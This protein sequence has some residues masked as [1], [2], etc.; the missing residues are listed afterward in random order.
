MLFD[1]LRRRIRKNVEHEGVGPGLRGDAREERVEL[2]LSAGPEVDESESQRA[3]QS[4]GVGHSRTARRGAVRDARPDHHDPVT[5]GVGSGFQPRTFVGSDLEGGD[6][7]VQ[8]EVEQALLHRRIHVFDDGGFV[9]RSG[10]ARHTDSGEDPFAVAADVEVEPALCDER[11]IGSGELVDGGP[12]GADV[13]AV[14]AEH[15]G[16]PR[17][18]AVISRDR[19]GQLGVAGHLDT[20][21]RRTSRLGFVNDREICRVRIFHRRVLRHGHRRDQ[22]TEDHVYPFFHASVFC[23]RFISGSRNDIIDAVIQN[24]ATG[25]KS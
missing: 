10:F 18:V 14:G 11:R 2:A 9:L 13:A 3:A 7:V 12:P 4:C 21:E 1:L 23:F 15:H 16:Q 17:G 22:Q 20:L 19:R 8:R 25:P 5:E 6:F 24:T